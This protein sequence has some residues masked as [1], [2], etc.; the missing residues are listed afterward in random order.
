MTT[1]DIV[2]H[3]Q[4]ITCRYGR[5]VAVDRADVFVRTNE[6]VAIIGGN[7]S[8][9]TTLVRA[10]MGFHPIAQGTFSINGRGV[11]RKRDW[12]WVYRSIGWMPQRQAT[13][14]FPLLVDELLASS[15][16]PAA[17]R[18]A[19]ESLGVGGLGAR[20]LATLSGGQ[21]QRVFLARALGC[22]A[23]TATLLIADEPTAALDFAGQE[24]MSALLAETG[25]SMLVVTH[26]R[27][28][29]ARCHRVYE[30]A[31]GRLQEVQ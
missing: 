11:D 26:D 5:T 3:A 17:A 28:L 30:M 16:A 27:R 18:S 2:L 20:N 8:G 21:L 13:G 15:T 9:K 10:L 19:A 25:H 31:A 7:G 29:V 12:G 23:G 22:L 4:G 6:R 14:T 1:P 24:A